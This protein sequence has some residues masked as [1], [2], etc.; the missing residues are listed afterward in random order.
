MISLF[1][2]T[3]ET[4]GN[5]DAIPREFGQQ[6]YRLTNFT[7]IYPTI[8][9]QLCHCVDLS[10]V[11]N[12]FTITRVLEL[13]YQ[14]I[15]LIFVTFQMKQV[16]YILTFFR[17][18]FPEKKDEAILPVHDVVRILPE[19]YI[20]RGIHSFNCD[21]FRTDKNVPLIVYQSSTH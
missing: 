2:R 14:G 19:P 6:V 1:L 9:V 16:C 3:L 12:F 21:V 8:I 10:T 20:R 17:V 11:V 18:M 4:T 5:T 15:K 13:R 7:I